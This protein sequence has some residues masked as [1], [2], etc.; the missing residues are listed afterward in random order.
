[1]IYVFEGGNIVYDGSTISNEEKNKAVAVEK[2]P[3]AEV[4]EGKI[5]VLKANMETNEV[6][7]EYI[8]KPVDPEI[9]QLKKIVADLTELVLFGGAI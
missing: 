2:L 4:I 7:F 3:I 8:D 5:A 6:Y 1:M 9:E